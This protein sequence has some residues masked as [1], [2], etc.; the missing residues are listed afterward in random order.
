MTAKS[1]KTAKPSVKKTVKK[2]A[3]KSKKST[4]RAKS[5]ASKAKPSKVSKLAKALSAKKATKKSATAKKL[6]TKA[7]STKKLVAKAKTTKKL[8]TKAKSTKKLTTKAKTTK[9]KSTKKLAT[10]AKSAKKLSTKS[11]KLGAKANKLA[12]KS[13]VAK[14]SKIKFKKKVS[15]HNTS[16]LKVKDIMSKNPLLMGPNDTLQTAAKKMH[17]KD[18]GCVFVT[19]NNRIA[20]IVTDR[21]IVV[22][23]ISHGSIFESLRLQDIMSPK[24]LYCFEEDSLQKA[25]QNMAKNQIHRLPVL[26]KQNKFVGVLSL[27]NIATHS[28]KDAGETLKIICK[29]K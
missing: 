19:E 8:A 29:N 27:G 12:S 26:N 22:R 13:K 20:G 16:K 5:Y 3:T 7:K 1:T 2:T 15:A 23:A 18:S 28:A 11:S 14:V 17:E 21:D 9:A 6:T 4:T 10:K 24:I 25:A